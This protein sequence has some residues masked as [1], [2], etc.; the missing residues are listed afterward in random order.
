MSANLMAGWKDVVQRDFLG[1]AKF[2]EV[3]FT[4]DAP[5]VYTFLCK[6]SECD[7]ICTDCQ[8][9]SLYLNPKLRSKTLM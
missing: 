8:G 3:I 1:Q 2:H 5:H 4:A 6:I 9:Q 7:C